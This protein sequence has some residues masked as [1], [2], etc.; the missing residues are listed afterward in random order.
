[1][2]EAAHQSFYRI[3]KSQSPTGEPNYRAAE[4]TFPKGFRVF[5]QLP[6]KLCPVV[7]VIIAAWTD[8]RTATE[9]GKII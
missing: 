7:K 4:A 5:D 6:G 2:E 8:R 3:D 1:V 9:A